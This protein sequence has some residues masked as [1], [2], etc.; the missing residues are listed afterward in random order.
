MN[1]VEDVLRFL[2]PNSI[3]TVKSAYHYRIS[4]CEICRI[5]LISRAKPG[6]DTSIIYIIYNYLYIYIYIYIYISDIGITIPLLKFVLILK[7][8]PAYYASIFYHSIIRGGSVE[9]W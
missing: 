9:Q 4:P 2:T 7:P 3:D 5:H 6:T 8:K 1:E